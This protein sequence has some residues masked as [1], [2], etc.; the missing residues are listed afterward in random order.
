MTIASIAILTS[1]PHIYTPSISDLRKAGHWNQA[2]KDA[3]TISDEYDPSKFPVDKPCQN[4]N[5]P[6]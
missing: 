2:D 3:E 5:F 6:N 4:S 1:S